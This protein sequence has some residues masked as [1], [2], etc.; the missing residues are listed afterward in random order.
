MSDDGS[1][2]EFYRRKHKKDELRKKDRKKARE[3]RGKDDKEFTQEERI[4]LIFGS[5]Q[6]AS[7]DKSVLLFEEE[8]KKKQKRIRWRS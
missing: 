2:E 7:R 4:D 3:L 8:N 6:K 5:I 1:N